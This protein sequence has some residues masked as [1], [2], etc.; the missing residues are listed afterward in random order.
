MLLAADAAGAWQPVCRT[1]RPDLTK[2]PAANKLFETSVTPHR[3][4]AN[5]VFTEFSVVLRADEQVKIKLSGKVEG[6]VV[7]EQIL[8]ST[9]TARASM[10]MSP[11]P[12]TSRCSITS[13]PLGSS[14]GRVPRISCI[15]RRPRRTTHARVRKQGSGCKIQQN[16]RPFEQRI[17]TRW[18]EH[19]GNAISTAR[20]LRFS[21]WT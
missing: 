18:P 3:F 12:S 11:R 8:P 10:W 13:C 16:S 14:C 7:A 15:A 5:E 21:R 6:R 9:A 20:A 19:S 1:L 4:Q 2:T 17:R